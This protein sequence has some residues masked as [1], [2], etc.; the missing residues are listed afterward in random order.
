MITF[1]SVIEN[2]VINSFYLTIYIYFFTF[3][4]TSDILLSFSLKFNICYEFNKSWEGVLYLLYP[5]L[6]FSLTCSQTYYRVNLE[7][8]FITGKRELSKN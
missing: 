6:A 4:D 2:L 8:K 1:D 5:N 3:K 7:N